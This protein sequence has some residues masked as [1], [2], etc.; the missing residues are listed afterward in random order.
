MKNVDHLVEQHIR[1][2]E[3]HLR[4]ID[5]LMERMRSKTATGRVPP[6]V[7]ARLLQLRAERD[8][9]AQ[10]FD[11]C[12]KQSAVDAPGAIAQAERVKGVLETI[13]LELEKAITAVL[14]H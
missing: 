11:E 6:E 10:E 14:D 1:Q 9:V 7:G 8:Q 12:R 4:H 3:S 2:S 13:G 5:E